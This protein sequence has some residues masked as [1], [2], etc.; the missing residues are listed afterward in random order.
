MREPPVEGR[1]AATLGGRAP[2]STSSASTRPIP[3]REGGGKSLHKTYTEKFEQN[4]KEGDTVGA[5]GWF[6]L[7]FASNALTAGF[8]REYSDAYDARASGLI[9]ATSS[10]ARR[11]NHSAKQ[12]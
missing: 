3:R 4:A 2:R 5:F 8:H 12:Q 6:F 1:R 7:D 11:P 9:S 10:K